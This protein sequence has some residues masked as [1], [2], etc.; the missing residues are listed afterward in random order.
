MTKRIFFGAT[1]LVVGMAA[2]TLA[3]SRFGYRLFLLDPNPTVEQFSLLAV[4]DDHRAR[5]EGILGAFFN[6]YNA[7]IQPAGA[8]GVK[9]SCDGFEE[10]LRPFCFEG[11]AVGFGPRKY[12]HWSP[13][14]ESFAATVS[15]IDPDYLFMYHLGLGFWAGMRHRGDASQVIDLARGRAIRPGFEGLI[16]DGY[17]FRLSLVDSRDR[18]FALVRCRD[19]GPGAAEACY[20]GVGRSLWFLYMDDPAEAVRKCTDQPRPIPEYCLTGL[21]LA[22]TFTG[23]EALPEVL[24]WIDSAPPE[25][26]PFLRRGFRIALVVRGLCDSGYLDSLVAG[27]PP[28]AGTRVEAALEHG[29]DCYRQ[30]IDRPDFYLAFDACN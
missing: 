11:A 9:S 25:A 26:F 20:Q 28:A 14:T 21:G 17:G 22:A 10:F 4:R 27:L 1:I 19:L 3:F 15:G 7:M 23:V 6:G 29:G 18:P 5:T 30:T 24:K 12:L 16:Y 8:K 13:R 2:A